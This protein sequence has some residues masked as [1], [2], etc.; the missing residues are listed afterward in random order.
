MDREEQA[1]EGDR[2]R[3]GESHQGT[4]DA[5]V[6]QGLLVGERLADAHERAERSDDDRRGDGEEVGERHV[7]MPPAGHDVVSE[8]VEAEDRHHG[9]PEVE[10]SVEEVPER[11]GKTASEGEPDQGAREGSGRDRPGEQEEVD[12]DPGPA[13]LRAPDDLDK[14]LPVLPPEE[15]DVA[16]RPQVLPEP[17]EAVLQGGGVGVDGQDQGLRAHPEFV[18]GKVGAHGRADPLE[19][20]AAGR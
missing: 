15:G 7:E 14:I 12:P 18:H 10:L 16:F 6:E 8:L 20:G 2:D 3:S 1:R 9:S 17:V 4:R 13:G 19:L 5:D 11:Q